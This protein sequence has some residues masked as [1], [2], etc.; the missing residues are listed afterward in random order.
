MMGLPG[1]ISPALEGSKQMSDWG[2]GFWH[3]LSCQSNLVGTLGAAGTP[4]SGRL[5]APHTP[6]LNS[7][8]SA[9]LAWCGHSWAASGSTGRWQ[10]SPSLKNVFVIS[11]AEQ[12]TVTNGPPAPQG[13]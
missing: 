9:A 8:P 4:S 12:I 13:P 10:L 1:P 3:W 11:A 7:T 2:W 5:V 6:S